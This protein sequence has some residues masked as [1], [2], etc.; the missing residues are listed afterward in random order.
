[1]FLTG[2]ECIFDQVCIYAHSIAEIQEND[3][4]FRRQS[5][6]NNGGERRIFKNFGIWPT[7]TVLAY[8]SP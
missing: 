1:M 4:E 5:L 8:F 3:E 7:T 6:L 2:H